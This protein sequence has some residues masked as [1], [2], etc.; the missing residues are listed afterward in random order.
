MYDIKKLKKKLG[1]NTTILT[2]KIDLIPYSRDMSL[3]YE[4]P[5]MVIIPSKVEDLLEIIDWAKR[6]VV[7]IIPR[8]AGTSVTGAVLG[9]K[10]SIIV[11]LTRLDRIKKVD[12]KN[13]YATV[14]AGVTCERLNKYLNK[15]KLFFPSQPGSQSVCT[16]GGMVATNAS[17]FRSIRYGT[18]KDNI[19]GLQ[20]IT[21]NGDILNL[22]SKTKTNSS[23][24][25]LLG[26]MFNSEGTLGIF[27][28]ITV[29]LS[30][31]PRKRHL[32]ILRY[33]KLDDIMDTLHMFLSG[34]FILSAFELIDSNSFKFIGDILE[35]IK[36]EEGDYLVYVEIENYFNIEEITLPS[37]SLLFY[38][39]DKEKIEYFWNVRSILS[40][41]LI[42]IDHNR[43]LF[44]IVEDI[45][46]P[47]TYIPQLIDFA[48]RES[49]KLN[50]FLTV[51]GHLATGNLHLNLLINPQNKEEV[52]NSFKFADLIYSNVLQNEGSI[53][54]EHGIGY[55]RASILKKFNNNDSIYRK[56]KQIFDPISILNPG[57]NRF[58]DPK[59]KLELSKTPLI[60]HNS[61]IQPIFQLLQKCSFCG[62]CR[63]GCPEFLKTKVEASSPRGKVAI[64]FYLISKF[65]I[66]NSIIDKIGVHCLNCNSICKTKCPV[67]IDIKEIILQLKHSITKTHN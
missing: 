32:L 58:W 4:K 65:L 11:D 47:I 49:Q 1:P 37:N 40:S 9:N 6:E 30:P 53:S 42:N 14:E 29:K 57:K 25:E 16:I 46:V 21:G 12:P 45:V 3:Y 63:D 8:G 44:P 54:G 10:D 31:I 41:K 33:K 51:F 23:G 17:G 19:Y 64:L 52:K 62:L 13:M 24:I 34:P 55:I 7:K 15:Y 18:T 36:I 35:R 43:R 20:V 38:T 26:I 50:L 60:T 28:E 61:E 39:D 2:K 59:I 67:N 56:I 22:G 66:S 5:A 27:S 48:K